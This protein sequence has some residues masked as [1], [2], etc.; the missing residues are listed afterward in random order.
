MKNYKILWIQNTIPFKI[1]IKKINVGNY[2][3]SFGT[4]PLIV[5]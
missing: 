4:K 3:N 2:D 5:K 1:V